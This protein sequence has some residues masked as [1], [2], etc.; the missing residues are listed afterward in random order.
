MS[1]YAPNRELG[2]AS[3]F[4]AGAIEILV[5]RHLRFVKALDMDGE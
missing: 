3:G 5:P 1:G 2:M 4:S